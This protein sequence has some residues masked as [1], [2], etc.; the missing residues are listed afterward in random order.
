MTQF[1]IYLGNHGPYDFL[2]FQ[3]VVRPI[4]AAL[5][6]AGHQVRYDRQRLLRAPAVNL[7]LEFFDD[8]F[9]KNLMVLKDSWG[10]GLIFGII[11]TEDLDDASVMANPRT[12]FRKRNFLKAVAAANFVWT[13]LPNAESL[14]AHA[15]FLRYGH[16]PALVEPPGTGPKD[17]D[18][19]LYGSLNPY[20]QR[21]LEALSRHGLSIEVTDCVLPDYVR[22]DL[23]SRSRVILDLR[24]N[25]GVRYCSPSRICYGLHT[26]ALVVAERCDTSALASL[27]A[28]TQSAPPGQVVDRVLA[29]FA[30]DS[31]ADHARDAHRRFGA[32]TSMRANVEELLALTHSPASAAT[33]SDRHPPVR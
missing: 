11:A 24:R 23:V 30:E 29:L 31:I 19:L 26:D 12:P 15:G 2:R 27:Y 6:E 13:L 4:G 32:E 20:R 33:S 28:Y 22:H 21:I 9:L 14:G 10:E 17:L 7:I 8:A 16:C 25:E 1:N 3:D 5:I 18:C